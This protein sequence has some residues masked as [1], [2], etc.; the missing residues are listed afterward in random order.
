MTGSLR[1][2]SKRRALLGDLLT[3]SPVLACL[4]IMLPRFLSPQFGLLDD[5]VTI[6]AARHVIAGDWSI[7]NMGADAGTGR[8]RPA[9]WLAYSAVYRLSGDDPFLFFLANGLVFAGITL[10]LVCLTRATGGRRLQAAVAGLLFAL[11]GPAVETFY[12]LSKGEPFQ[13]LWLVGSLLVIAALP[14][15]RS[16]V[17]K[18]GVLLLAAVLVFLADATKETSL[19][20]IPVSLAWCLAAWF[21]RRNTHER[22]GFEARS[23]YLLATVMATVVYLGLRAYFVRQATPADNYAAHYGLQLSQILATG[24]R[25]AGWLMHDFPYMVPV[26]GLLGVFWVLRKKAPQGGL[27][28]DAFLWMG[29]WVLVFLPWGAPTVEYFLL[30]FAAG[31][32]V[33]SGILIGRSGRAVPQAGKTEWSFGVTGLVL[34]AGLFLTTLP[35]NASNGQQQL[36][37]DAANADM[38]D[39]LASTLPQGSMVI[40]NIQDP[41]EYVAEI[42]LHLDVIRGRP[43]L[44]VNHFS[45]QEALLSPEVDPPYVVLAP[46]V[47]NQPR[48][49]VR[50]GVIEPTVRQWNESMLQFLGGSL[51]V[52]YETERR[53]RLLTVDLLRVFCPLFPAREYCHVAGPAID[54]RLF[55]YGW[56]VYRLA[57]EAQ[58]SVA[59]VP[60]LDRGLGTRS[61]PC[62]A[63]ARLAPPRRE[64]AR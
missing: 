43:D 25:W 28:F 47:E 13:L 22:R 15:L 63:G 53:F 7:W 64:G 48:L 14:H 31:C 2:I 59:G 26:V 60:L 32:S 57:G 10:G 33:F 37:V 62:P 39:Y 35:N 42:A 8:F 12:T 23:A 29:G 44:V 20:M 9:Y 54:R 41:N 17:G 16:T 6:S 51:E 46:S 34:A 11:S 52:E 4:L 50:M 40:V 19:A 61:A 1:L 18:A 56:T 24:F 5:G 30:P 36:A 49:A 27:L 3:Y 45:Y 55:S 58:G 21:R 38:L